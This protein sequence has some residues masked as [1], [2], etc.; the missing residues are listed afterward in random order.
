MKP[1]YILM[2]VVFAAILIGVT[3]SESIKKKKGS[4]GEDKKKIMDAAQKVLPDCA[5]YTIAY[6]QYS[7]RK[8]CGNNTTSYYYNYIAAF[9]PN[10]MVVIPIKFAG[11]EIVTQDHFVLDR[12]NVSSIKT[13]KGW[14]TFFD[15]NGKEICTLGVN[16]SNILEGKYFPLNIQQPEEAEKFRNFLDEFTKAVQPAE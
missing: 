5:A 10:E 2:I 3:V 11:K 8:S 12:T 7:F 13:K 14:S 9:R 6:A 1:E 15:K 16:A 4:S